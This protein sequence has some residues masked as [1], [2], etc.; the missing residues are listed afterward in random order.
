M[1]AEEIIVGDWVI[2]LEDNVVEL[3]HSTG[4]SHRFHVNHVA[5]EAKPQ[6]NGGMRLRVGVESGGEV[7]EGGTIDVPPELEG[8]VTDLFGEA[9]RRREELLD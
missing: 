1:D 4:L 5:V 6:D 7:V 8:D 2:R 9:K 3:L